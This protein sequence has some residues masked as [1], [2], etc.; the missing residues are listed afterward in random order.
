MEKEKK[1]KMGGGNEPKTQFT[2]KNFF[3]FTF[4]YQDVH[5][6]CCLLRP[7]LAVCVFEGVSLY[8]DKTQN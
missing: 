2:R 5:Y 6:W 4:F 3:H 1:K 8:S 7:G